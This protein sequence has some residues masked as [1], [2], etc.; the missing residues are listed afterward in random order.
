EEGRIARCIEAIQT[1][2][3]W[4][5]AIETVIV[6]NMSTD[7]TAE[8]GRR[9][10]VKVINADGFVGA[11]R[12]A[13]ARATNAPWL[14]FIDADCV[15]DSRF[16]KFAY[17]EIQRGGGPLF[18]SRIYDERPTEISRLLSNHDGILPGPRPYIGGAACV[19]SREFFTRMGGFDE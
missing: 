13:G 15:I 10:G 7:R 9:L 14:L 1:Q 12:N 5:G 19:I 2:D 17:E 16:L 8:V 6:D 18:G 3:I 11:A 4:L